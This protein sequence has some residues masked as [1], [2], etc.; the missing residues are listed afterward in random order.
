MS[1]SYV[2]LPRDIVQVSG[3]DA[4]S[5]LQGLISQDIDKV[6]PDL[7]AYGTLLTPREN[8]STTSS[9]PSRTAISCSIANM[10]A[11]KTS[12]PASPGSSCAQTF[13]SNFWTTM[14]FSLSSVRRPRR[15]SVSNPGPP[16]PKHMAASLR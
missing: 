5:F 11:A 13:N 15:G 14:R 2:K 16:Q 4:R 6:E 10:V 7:S 1:V 9:S 3:T 12:Q 8:T